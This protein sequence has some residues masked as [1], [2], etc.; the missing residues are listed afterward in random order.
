MSSHFV[1]I[2]YYKF[3]LAIINYLC[4]Y[5]DLL[6]QLA[7]A[8]VYSISTIFSTTDHI[9]TPTLSHIFFVNYNSISFFYFPNLIQCDIYINLCL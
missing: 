2:E 5:Q 8:K 3:N 4:F 7:S 1:F 9:N 6:C